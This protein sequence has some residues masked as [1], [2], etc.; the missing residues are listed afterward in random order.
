MLSCTKFLAMTNKDEATRLETRREGCPIVRLK[1]FWAPHLHPRTL[2]V[3]SPVL[4]SRA[5]GEAD[6]ATH[7]GYVPS[8]GLYLKA[9]MNQGGG[10]P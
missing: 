5:D 2:K 8:Y 6:T 9:C 7:L 4:L 10:R 3:G 1:G